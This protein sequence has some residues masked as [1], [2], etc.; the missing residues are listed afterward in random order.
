M[1]GV[2]L[3]EADAGAFRRPLL[4]PLQILLPR[5][6][7]GARGGG[8]RR[9]GVFDSGGGLRPGLGDPGGG[10]QRQGKQEANNP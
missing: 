1:V 7:A 10:Q 6:A 9:S 2:H 3:V 5:D 8:G 4:G